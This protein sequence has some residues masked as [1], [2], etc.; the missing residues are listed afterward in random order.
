MLVLVLKRFGTTKL[1]QLTDCQ[2]RLVDQ[3]KS[4]GLTSLEHH[5]NGVVTTI[6]DVAVQNV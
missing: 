6:F 2:N 1:D 4:I 5:I 3:A